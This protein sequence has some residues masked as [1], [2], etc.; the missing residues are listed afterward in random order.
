MLRLRSMRISAILRPF[1]RRCTARFIS[2]AKPS[3]AI[4]TFSAA[5]VVPPGLVTS[6]RKAAARRLVGLQQRARARDGGAREFFGLRRAAGLPPSPAS[7]SASTI[8]NT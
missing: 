6:S 3:S 1:A 7:V 2:A 8:R 4:R 5:S